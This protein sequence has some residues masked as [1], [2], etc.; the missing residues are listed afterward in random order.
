M[1]VATRSFQN[2]Y[3]YS[4]GGRAY[5]EN[6]TQNIAMLLLAKGYIEEKA[7]QQATGNC[8]CHGGGTY[9]CAFPD[10]FPIDGQLYMNCS[11][12]S[13][14]QHLPSSTDNW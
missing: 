10:I 6:G 1:Q 12:S 8:P 5:A 14:E 7:Y 13:S 2:I 11:M 4:A 9:S 3:G